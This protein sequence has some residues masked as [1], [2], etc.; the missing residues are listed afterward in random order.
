MFS[1]PLQKS[2][3]AN[4]IKGRQNDVLEKGEI[5][6]GKLLDEWVSSSTRS[7]AIEFMEVRYF[8]LFTSSGT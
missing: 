1:A 4:R 5:N 3:D 6:I 7:E 8:P 2:V